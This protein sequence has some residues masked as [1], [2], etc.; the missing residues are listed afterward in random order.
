MKINIKLS[1]SLLLLGII[2]I[3]G[4]AQQQANAPEAPASQGAQAENTIIIKNYAFNP[5]S[6]SVS[7]GATV[8]WTNEEDISHTV[9]MEGVFD[10]GALTKGKSFSYKFDHKGEFAY[11][12]SFHQSMNGKITVR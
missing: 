1:A 3:I 4:C 9:T 2:F 12:C 11:Y 8:T 5:P 7:K 10:S 6:L